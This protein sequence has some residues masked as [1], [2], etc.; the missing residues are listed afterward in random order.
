MFK[1]EITIVKHVE[2]KEREK[3]R[4]I[5]RSMLFFKTYFV[6]NEHFKLQFLMKWNAKHGWVE[7]KLQWHK[8]SFVFFCR[9]I[10]AVDFVVIVVLFHF[11]FTGNSL[12][13]KLYAHRVK[14]LKSPQHTKEIISLTFYAVFLQWHGRKMESYSF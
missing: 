9:K 11:L 4:Y 14:T 12:K 8:I 6:F 7:V 13:L 2:G 5:F 3:N 10:G 1:L